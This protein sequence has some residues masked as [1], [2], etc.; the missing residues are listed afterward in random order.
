MSKSFRYLTYLLAATMFVFTLVL[1][2]YA[3]Y[4]LGEV[5]TLMGD[6]P[7]PRHKPLI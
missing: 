3:I 6:P 7:Y 1:V 2:V 4:F 5:V